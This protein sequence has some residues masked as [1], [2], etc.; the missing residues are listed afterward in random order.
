MS[1]VSYEGGNEYSMSTGKKKKKKKKKKGG[2]VVPINKLPP[3]SNPK[4]IHK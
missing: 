2:A 4:P 1:R 3:S